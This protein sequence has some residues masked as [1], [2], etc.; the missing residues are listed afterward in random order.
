[1]QM[2]KEYVKPTVKT[3]GADDIVEAMGPVS[4]GSGANRPNPVEDTVGPKTGN[5]GGLQNLN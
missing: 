1:M 2:P 4:C 5:S 3:L